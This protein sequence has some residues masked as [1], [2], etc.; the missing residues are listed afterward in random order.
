MTTMPDAINL[1][2]KDMDVERSMQKRFMKGDKLSLST[3]M[4]RHK[5]IIY[6]VT[7]V[8][9]MSMTIEREKLRKGASK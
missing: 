3:G 6:I 1:Y 4:K 7:R 5:G 2:W 8:G 9:K